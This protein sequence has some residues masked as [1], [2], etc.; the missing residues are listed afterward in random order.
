MWDKRAV[1]D[2]L[3]NALKPLDHNNAAFKNG[4]VTWKEH[5]VRT[6]PVKN[7]IEVPQWTSHDWAHKL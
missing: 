7:S 4:E 3:R 6:T 5:R 1:Y 2:S